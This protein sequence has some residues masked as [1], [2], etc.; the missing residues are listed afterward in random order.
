MK[1]LKEGLENV[2]ITYLLGH[3]L[4]VRLPDFV[5]LEV[6]SISQN[7][8]ELR[9]AVLETGAQVSVPKEVQAGQIE[10]HALRFLFF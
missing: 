8:S 9:L 4:E 5:E 7:S 1:F 3:V 2:T 10:L 6:A